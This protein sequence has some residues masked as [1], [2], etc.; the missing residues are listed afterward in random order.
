MAVAS[1][2][3]QAAESAGL[4]AANVAA[5]VVPLS[6]GA[7]LAAGLALAWLPWAQAVE[8]ELPV[9]SL[10]LVDEPFDPLAVEPAVAAAVAAAVVVVAAEVVVTAVA[11]A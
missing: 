4:A 8:A 2:V 3:L 9:A 5:A 11:V 6:L 10:E 1:A 7:T